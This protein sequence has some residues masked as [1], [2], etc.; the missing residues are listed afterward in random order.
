MAKK[1]E[2]KKPELKCP[3]CGNGDTECFKYCEDVIESR[4]IFG[5]NDKGVLEVS[6][7]SKSDGDGE[8]SRLYCEPCGKYFSIPKDIEI[9]WV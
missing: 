8:N 6:G 9:D 5:F 3:H 7:I 1:E 2:K 4:S